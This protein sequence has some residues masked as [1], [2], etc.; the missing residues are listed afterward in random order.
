LIAVFC[1]ATL[2]EVKFLVTELSSLQ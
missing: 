2:L 1:V